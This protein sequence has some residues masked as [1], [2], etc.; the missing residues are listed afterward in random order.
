MIAFWA[1]FF[2]LTLTHAQSIKLLQTGRKVSLRGL[3]VVS[4][5]IIWASGSNG[6]VARS[7]DGGNTWKW[8][9][10]RGYEQKDFRDIKAFDANTAIIM[11]IEEPAV[12][13]KTKDGGIH[14]IKVFED[15]NK[16]MFLD[17]M[18]FNG[19]NGVV[20][21]DP[22]NNKIFLATTHNS[23][24]SWQIVQNSPAALEGEG[25]FASSGSNIQV[26]GDSAD[27]KLLYAS[28][29][30]V[31]RLFLGNDPPVVLD[32]LQGKESQGANSV[33]ALKGKAVITGGDFAHD[34][35]REKNC[36]LLDLKDMAHPVFS[37]PVE[38]PHGYRS[39]VKALTDSIW[40][41]CGTSGVDYSEDGGKH[42]DLISRQ[43]FHV[44]QKAKK[45][46]AVYLAGSN[47]RIA[48]LVF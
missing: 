19:K 12:I 21:G 34:S 35:I 5:Q 29:G 10:I 48:Q 16:G 7:T 39:C 26:L 24:D 43:G 2:S 33:A 31:S 36:I 41:S 23:G 17:A 13:L 15:N 8:Q 30:K 28:G 1:C 11:A 47:G 3:S 6:T 20:I 38:P 46:N 22:V 9:M 37:Y 44:V 18:D 27:M 32:L 40:I 14:W 45:G 25:F 42:W 4:D